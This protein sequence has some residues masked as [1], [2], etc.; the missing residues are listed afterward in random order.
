MDRYHGLSDAFRERASTNLPGPP[1][2]EAPAA[3]TPPLKLFHA[4]SP[5]KEEPTEFAGRDSFRRL[6]N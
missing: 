1:E 6:S 4:L 3:P 5:P 2:L